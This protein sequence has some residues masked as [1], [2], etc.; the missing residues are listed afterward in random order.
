MCAVY[1]FVVQCSH[2]CIDIL[3]SLVSGLKFMKIACD[4]VLTIHHSATGV[5][6][7]QVSWVDFWWLHCVCFSHVYYISGV[8]RSGAYSDLDGVLVLFVSYI[9]F[10]ERVIGLKMFLLCA[11]LLRRHSLFLNDILSDTEVAHN[12]SSFLIIDNTQDS[13]VTLGTE[14]IRFQLKG[15]VA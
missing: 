14:G 4:K 15:L 5:Q 13:I 6:D 7:F 10:L 9:I 12:P 8:A 11:I 1:E 2:L 3:I